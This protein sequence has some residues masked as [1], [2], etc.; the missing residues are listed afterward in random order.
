M[1]IKNMCE[2]YY[3]LVL[4]FLLTLTNGDRDLAEDLTQETF[5]RAIRR[6]DTFRGDA[7]VSTWLCQ[8]AKYTFW[9][10][11][12]KNNKFKQIPMEEAM[13]LPNPVKR[14]RRFKIPT[15]L[16]IFLGV[17]G[18]LFFAIIVVVIINYILANGV[19]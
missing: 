3:Q 18:Y 2:E 11:L 17:L 15:L 13:E 5:L 8:I 16:K 9:Q 6:S 14:K 10:Y 1:N 4:G 19:F 12:E 7:K